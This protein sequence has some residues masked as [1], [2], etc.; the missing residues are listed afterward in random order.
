MPQD[1]RGETLGVRSEGCSLTASLL[2]GS[3]A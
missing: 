3:E 1:S 2:T